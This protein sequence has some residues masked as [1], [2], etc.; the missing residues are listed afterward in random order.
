MS[1]EAA[2]PGKTS[3][4]A[5][6]AAWII[7]LLASLLPDILWREFVK[8]DSSW[9][10][11]AKIGLLGALLAVSF[12]WEKLR[13]L[14]K[15]IVVLI[16][17]H[18]FERI[19][20]LVVS[21]PF[22]QAWFG[23][24]NQPFTRSMLNTQLQRLAVSLLMIGLLLIL[25]YKRKEFFL[26]PGSLKASITPVRWLGFP[27]ADPW[28]RFGGQFA[29]YITLGILAFLLIGNLPSSA[30]LSRLLPMLPFVL[31]FAAM[32]AFNEE[33][34]Y[35]A[36]IIPTLEGS[37]NPTPSVLIAASFFGIGHFYGVPYGIVGVLMST[38]LG[39]F[40]GKAMVETRGFFWAWLI[41]F[42]QDV[43]IFSFLAM[44]SVTPGG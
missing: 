12:F 38:F 10:F 20:T 13:L 18:S 2:K 40:L 36:C 8:A 16:G 43:M 1:S 30:A 39:W 34:T 7:V 26:T 37:L 44:G 32:N 31:L 15:F 42:L 22:W 5:L 24:A 27:K 41:H 17:N 25:G 23:G 14:R 29:V 35:R 19:M 6:T 9:I 28:T 33:M 3:R 11:W 21:L 4:F